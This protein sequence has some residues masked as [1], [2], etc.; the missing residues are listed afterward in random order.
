[1]NA[2]KGYLFTVTLAQHKSKLILP[3]V[4]KLLKNRSL[5]K[6][7]EIASFMKLNADQMPVWIWIF[8]LPQLL[9]FMSQEKD[10]LQQV[11]A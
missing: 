1:M 8:W 9:Q 7:K 3:F 2:L 4:L 6:N 10:S 5:A 11:V